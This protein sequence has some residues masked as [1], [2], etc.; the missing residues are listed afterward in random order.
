MEQIQIEK[1]INE[2]EI[3]DFRFLNY[4][5]LTVFIEYMKLQE[6]GLLFY[7]SHKDLRSKSVILSSAAPTTNKNSFNRIRAN[8]WI[9]SI[10]LKNVKINPIFI[11]DD[12][13]I[14]LL[15][16]Y[17]DNTTLLEH[18]KI[19]FSKSLIL[20]KVANNKDHCISK[21]DKLE[22]KS[23]GMKQP[24]NTCPMVVINKMIEA[25]L[26]HFKIGFFLKVLKLIPNRK[27]EVP[28]T[29][30]F[31]KMNQ[32]VLG[33]AMTSAKISLDA[34]IEC[35][36]ININKKNT[37]CYVISINNE[38]FENEN[39]VNILSHYSEN[40]INYNTLPVLKAISSIVDKNGDLRS[41]TVA[42]NVYDQLCLNGDKQ[43]RHY[44]IPKINILAEYG[45]IVKKSRD[46]I[47]LDKSFW[48]ANS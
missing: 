36:W 17:V 22:D 13:L 42:K 2:L 31:W 10:D 11:K 29:Y 48:L 8:G 28:N 18:R 16:Q 41:D 43:S 35:K 20:E 21:V 5:D 12:T 47:N 34:L 27:I 40:I 19:S 44:I 7:K 25:K 33:N 3:T 4:T 15:K 1:L 32:D 46:H 39:T 23:I 26:S 6:D 30:Q 14:N 9:T 45:Y 24:F 38:L 37:K